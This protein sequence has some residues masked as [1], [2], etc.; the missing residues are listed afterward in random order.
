VANSSASTGV[1]WAGP[2]ITAGKNALINGGMDIWQRGTSFTNSTS[3]AADRWTMYAP[4]TTITQET[5]VVPTGFRYS[6]K[7]AATASTLP[8]ISQVVETLNAVQFAGQT[9]TLSAYF[10]ASVATTMGFALGYSTSVDNP[11]AGTWTY[12][13]STGSATGAA[14]T[15]GAFNRISVQYNVPSTAKS[16]II[17]VYPSANIANGTNLYVT[18]FQMEVGSVATAFSRA[19]GTLQGE[20][21]ACQRYYWRA[22]G[23]ASNIIATVGSY[24]STNGIGYV[25]NPVPMRIAGASIDYGNL[26]YTRPG[27]GTTALTS[28]TI[29]TSMPATT[30]LLITAASGLAGNTFGFLEMNATNGYL[31]VSAEL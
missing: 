30:A 25:Q 27:T 17:T 9:V 19:G 18:G 28:V 20:L 22:T 10:S 12:I 15:G 16:F 14:G 31:G 24:S 11:A 29:Y 23:N 1:S 3:Y 13:A 5:S 7:I 21:A 26:D 2:I 8:Y 6:M 4:T